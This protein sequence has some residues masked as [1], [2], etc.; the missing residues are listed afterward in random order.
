MVRTSIGRLTMTQTDLIPNLTASQVRAI[1]NAW[2]LPPAN[3]WITAYEI[4]ESR[5]TLEALVRKGIM[6][7]K[8]NVLG[9]AFFPRQTEYRLLNGLRRAT[10]PDGTYRYWKA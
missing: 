8:R 4:G 10:L 2:I 9:A 6:R 7:V 5:I 1:R 3:P